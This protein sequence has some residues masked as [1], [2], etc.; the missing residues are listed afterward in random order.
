LEEA[1]L[2]ILW[3]YGML[4]VTLKNQEN[5]SQQTGAYPEFEPACTRMRL[6]LVTARCILQIEVVFCIMD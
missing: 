1:F 3:Y 5:I 2:S 6:K 4:G